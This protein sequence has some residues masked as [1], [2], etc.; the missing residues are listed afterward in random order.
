MKK[1]VKFIL[2][3]LKLLKYVIN[4]RDKINNILLKKKIY[5]IKK[6]NF[7]YFY[8]A[9]FDAE[10][11]I[12]EFKSSKLKPEKGYIT[13]Y[14]GA[15]FPIKI[16]PHILN[17]KSNSIDNI[18]IPSNW[19]TDIIEISSVLEVVK[20]SKD[21]F[22]MIEVGSGWGCWMVISG[23]AAKK[24]NKKVSLIGVEASNF[25]LKLSEEILNK[26]NFQEHE[27]KLFNN[28]IGNT[29]GWSI[30][31]KFDQ[32]ENWGAEAIIYPTCHEVE[33]AK[34]NPKLNLV[35]RIF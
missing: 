6:S 32:S 21:H 35:K 11:N 23:L 4:F 15:K 7:F 19:H 29:V 8:S 10:K 18:P 31:P 30:F 33:N 9:D 26:N 14:M 3:K 28:I 24:L 17:E 25:Y 13:N 20:N 1:I 22:K 5:K 12:I 27:Y 16:Y 34:K 2:L